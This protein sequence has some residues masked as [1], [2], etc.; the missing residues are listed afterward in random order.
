M[1]MIHVALVAALLSV[2]LAA[3]AKL[4]LPHLVADNMVI[5]QQTEVRL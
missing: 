4:R 3:Q 1:K 2:S 5:Q